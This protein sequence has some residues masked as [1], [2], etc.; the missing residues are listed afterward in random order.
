MRKLRTYTIIVLFG[1]SCLVYLIFRENIILYD[2]IDKTI[3]QNL[4]VLEFKKVLAL[5]FPDWILYNLPDAVWV[6]TL[7][8]ILLYI[9]DFRLTKRNIPWIISPIII[10]YSIEFGQRYNWINGT[11]DTKDL[12]FILIG[13]AIP[14]IEI[15][16]TNHYEKK[17]Y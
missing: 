9:W 10:A 5:N 14:L 2:W 1:F 11:Y 3:F 6:M 7:I 17:I 8:Y 16:K 15:I 4:Q 13:S 12:I